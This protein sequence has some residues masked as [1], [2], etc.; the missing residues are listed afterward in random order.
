MLQLKEKLHQ[1]LKCISTDSMA[2]LKDMDR[3]LPLIDHLLFHGFIKE[4][5]DE[6]QEKKYELTDKGIRMLKNTKKSIF[7]CRRNALR[8][9]ET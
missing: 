1:I 6:C 5:Q 3:A 9:I 8:R 7:R 2:K 4:L